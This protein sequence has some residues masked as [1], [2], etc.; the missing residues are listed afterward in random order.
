[1]HDHVR[2]LHVRILGKR[3]TEGGRIGRIGNSRRDDRIIDEREVVATAGLVELGR[4][5]AIHLARPV[6]I[7]NLLL[8]RVYRKHLR[9]YGKLASARRTI[10]GI[11]IL[12]VL[13]PVG[14]LAAMLRRVEAVILVGNSPE[15]ALAR[16]EGIVRLLL[17]K[18]DAQNENFKGIDGKGRRHKHQQKGQK[19]E[20]RFKTFHTQSNLQN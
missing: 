2:T 20:N 15:S 12:Q 13:F 4:L 1:M 14:H 8:Q 7:D 9:L 16:S 19:Q 17:G 11:G 10:I 5:L 3:D 18:L 6:I